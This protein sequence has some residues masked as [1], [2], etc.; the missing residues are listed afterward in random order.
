MLL[1]AVFSTRVDATL[2]PHEPRHDGTCFEHVAVRSVWFIL[3]VLARALVNLLCQREHGKFHVIISPDALE[4]HVQ[5]MHPRRRK[6]SHRRARSGHS[7]SEASLLR[8]VPTS[9][10]YVSKQREAPKSPTPTADSDNELQVGSIITGG[11]GSSALSFSAWPNACTMG[12]Y[13]H[14]RLPPCLLKRIRPFPFGVQPTSRELCL[15]FGTS[16]PQTQPSQPQLR[17]D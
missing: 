10:R 13:V 7:G 1:L 8:T 4:A 15:L 9:L 6:P 16:S 3:S 14:N 11:R 2:A 5:C 12:I 17:R